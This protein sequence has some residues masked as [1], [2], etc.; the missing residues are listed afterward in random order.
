MSCHLSPASPKW[1]TTSSDSPSH[2]ADLV[3]HHGWWK[4][5]VSQASLHHSPDPQG[6][7]YVCSF[8]PRYWIKINFVCKIAQPPLTFGGIRW[9][10]I[11]GRLK[12][13]GTELYPRLWGFCYR[14]YKVNPMGCRQETMLQGS[15][16]LFARDL[17]KCMIWGV[18]DLKSHRILISVL[19]IVKT[20][21]RRVYV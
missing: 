9:R 21:N 13:A 8:F 14:L 18:H 2:R 19:S 11:E 1:K 3:S 4:I 16:V 7:W 12:P 15:F 17:S 20:G 10:K 5:I 6:L